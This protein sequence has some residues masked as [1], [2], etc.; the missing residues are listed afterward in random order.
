MTIIHDEP[1][2]H[3]EDEF[4][5]M[6]QLLVES[7]GILDKPLNW[8][9]ADLENWKYASADEPREHFTGRAH[10]WRDA[11]GALVGYLIRY[12]DTVF[13]QIHP[14]HRDVE[15]AMIAWAEAHWSHHEGYTRV[16][17]YGHDAYRQEILQARGYADQGAT[18]NMW[19]YDLTR[20]Y[21]VPIPEGFHV[22]AVADRGDHAGRIDLE[23]AV[24]DAPFLDEV[25]FYGK[26][27]SP[28]YSYDW[29]LVMVA[30][31]GA[32]VA[33]ALAWI[34]EAN[35]LAEIDPVGTHPDYRRRGLAKTLLAETFNRLRAQG[36]RE[37]Y[38]GSG[39][40]PNPSNYLYG[41]LDPVQKYREHRWIKRVA[42]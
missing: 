25:W 8:G 12:Y 37:A 20:L 13:P 16:A 38:I 30:P 2:T 35:A 21:D 24:F 27:S 28:I 33:F 32:Y 36:V 14:D 9:L 1:Y 7:W 4:R 31:D 11:D 19:R 40:E 26:A 6:R 23:R 17:A 10:L 39:V 42:E 3:S 41:S 15:P 29:D 18:G 5:E 22:E 34:D